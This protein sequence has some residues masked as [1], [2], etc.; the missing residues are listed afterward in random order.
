VIT[1]CS[2]R[3]GLFISGAMPYQS[4]KESKV[5]KAREINAEK[6]EAKRSEFEPSETEASKEIWIY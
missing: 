4:L 3:L 5:E 2:S 6:S 1:I